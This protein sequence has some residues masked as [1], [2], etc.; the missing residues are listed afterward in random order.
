MSNPLFSALGG[1][2]Q[3]N[4]I[5]RIKNEIDN[6]RKTF[7]G[8]PKDEVQKMLNNGTLSQKQFNEYAATANQIMSL[9][10][11]K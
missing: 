2:H 4:Q 1:N 11:Q 7:N 9:M 5:T 10:A 3:N 6:F 8:N